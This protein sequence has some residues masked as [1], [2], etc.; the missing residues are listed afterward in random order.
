MPVHK[1]AFADAS[2]ERSPRQDG[3]NLTANLLD[4][5]HGRPVTIGV[6]R[7]WPNQILEGKII[8]SDYGPGEI[9]AMQKR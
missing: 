7:F 3:G 9:I 2:R 4:Q 1:F 5:R 8:V 6:G